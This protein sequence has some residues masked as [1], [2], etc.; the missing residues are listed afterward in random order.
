M[1]VR[2]QNNSRRSKLGKSNYGKFHNF[3]KIN[4]FLI[5]WCSCYCHVSWVSFSN[6]KFIKWN[7]KFDWLKFLQTLLHYR[8][9]SIG[10]HD[11]ITILIS[12]LENMFLTFKEFSELFEWENF[13]LLQ[14]SCSI[15]YFS[16]EILQSK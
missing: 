2:N 6:L 15:E 1:C 8:I 7:V 14:K 9:K 16:S 10:S 5:L 13:V 11:G 3:F 12:L 4:A